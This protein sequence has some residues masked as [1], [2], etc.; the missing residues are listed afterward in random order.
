MGE[1][2]G[3]GDTDR[4]VAHSP[5]LD[6]SMSPMYP[7]SPSTRR[8]GG[9]QLDEFDVSLIDFLVEDGRS[10][11]RKIAETIGLTESTVAA[12]LRSLME[13]KVV[14]VRAVVDWRAAGFTDPIVFFLRVSGRPTSEVL[15]ELKDV[16]E[17]QSTA[18]VFGSADV[19]IRVLLRGVAGAAQFVDEQLGRI[20]GLS[21]AFFLLDVESVKYLSNFHSVT[22][23]EN[24][25]PDFPSPV[26]AVDDCDR[27]IIRCLVSDARQSWRQVGRTLGISE[28]TVRV[29]VRRLESSGLISVIAQLDPIAAGNHVEF[30][31]IGITTTTGSQAG[32]LEFAVGRRELSVVM[33]TVGQFDVMAFAV[34]DSRRHLAELLERLRAQPGVVTTETWN[35]STVSLS[36]FPWAR[37]ASPQGGPRS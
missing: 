33:R 20:A 23:A 2:A 7:V 4:L 3:E 12:R 24:S 19:I 30:A 22:L 21:V 16:P 18:R 13:R 35:V 32:V 15:A 10:S 28:S 11:T 9:T 1:K 25:V 8:R 37:F 17:I 34:V 26:V 36:A 14:R 31:W 5:D 27:D 29:R 6:P